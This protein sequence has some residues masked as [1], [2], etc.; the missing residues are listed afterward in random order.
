MLPR[1][2]NLWYCLSQMFEGALMF[3][4]APAS[5]SA[6]LRNACKAMLRSRHCRVARSRRR[7]PF[8]RSARFVQRWAQQAS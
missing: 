1:L 2:S 8:A 6:A 3:T 4:S 7:V 5:A